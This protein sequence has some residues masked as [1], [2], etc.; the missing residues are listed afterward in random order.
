MARSY[1]LCLSWASSTITIPNEDQTL[2]QLHPGPGHITTDNGSTRAPARPTDGE[3]RVILLCSQCS[4]RTRP[5]WPRQYH[6]P[7]RGT[8]H[9]DDR[10]RADDSPATSDSRSKCPVP[11]SRP[12]AVGHQAA[13]SKNASAIPFQHQGEAETRTSIL[14]TGR[15]QRSQPPP[16]RHPAL[17]DRSRKWLSTN[18][19]AA[20]GG[21]SGA[22]GPSPRWTAPLPRPA[23]SSRRGQPP[24]RE[25]AD[26]C[27][28]S[29]IVD[30][31]DVIDPEVA[32][33]SSITNVQNSLFVPS[34]GRWV[35]RRPTYDLSRL[36]DIP[37]AFPESLEDLT[38][39][40]V[41]SDDD[42]ARAKPRRGPSLS[43]VLSDTQYAILP[44]DATLEGWTDDEI[45]M[46]NDHVRHMLHSRRS[47][48][49]QRLKAFGQYTRRPLGFLVTLYATL[50]TLFGLAWVLFLIGWIYVGEKQLYVINVID[51]V[52]VA[53][54]AVVGDGMIPWRLVDTYRMAHVS[55]L[56]RKTWKLR[57]KMLLPGLKDHND[58]PTSDPLPDVEAAQ[59]AQK[60]EFVP[61]LSDKEQATLLHH[62]KKLSRSHTFYKPHETET[63]NAFPLRLLI[64][65]VLLLDLHS[66]LQVTLGAVTWG[67][68]YETRPAAVTTTVL[69]CSIATNA[70]AGILISVGDRRTRKKDV[71]E[72]LVKQELTAEAMKRV[73][74]EKEKEEKEKEEQKRREEEGGR[75]RGLLA[76]VA[77]FVERIRNSTDKGSRSSSEKQRDK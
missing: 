47:K 37:G 28:D 46:L 48:F 7:R 30:I 33:L 3:G 58:L 31:L 64:A 32:T 54:F 55:H 36:P 15:V 52:L 6:T 4:G 74:K 9:P 62:Q 69:C 35:N 50:I 39:Q 41:G 23:T 12:P 2:C 61:V 20:A 17:V 59:V 5:R 45:K 76:P 49:K 67:I 71:I 73:R 60:D 26:D 19:P 25:D 10:T 53:L 22:R 56:H 24:E 27:Y 34:L 1:N 16:R 68:P 44:E 75:D 66:C 21:R 43:S 63:H 8:A 11:L 14:L 42:D 77:P 57:K 40:D 18:H 13:P 72:R 51:Y 29:R 65:I 70:L 38:K